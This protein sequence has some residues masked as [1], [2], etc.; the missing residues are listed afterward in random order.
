[1]PLSPGDKALGA[2]RGVQRAGDDV[3]EPEEDADGAAEL[4]AEG[5]A[6]HEVDAAALDWRGQR[7]KYRI[8]MARTVA[9]GGVGDRTT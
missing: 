2:G 5:P 7:A 6:Q 8:S 3:S 1:M 9:S 4:G